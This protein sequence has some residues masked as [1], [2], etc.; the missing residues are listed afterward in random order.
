MKSFDMFVHSVPAS[1]LES[2][3][4]LA[5]GVDIA[6]VE[7]GSRV[8]SGYEVASISLGEVSEASAGTTLEYLLVSRGTET[9][10]EADIFRKP[11]PRSLFIDLDMRGLHF[12][13]WFLIPDCVLF[14]ESHY[15]K[16]KEF[17]FCGRLRTL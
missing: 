10:A 17:L 2:V 12:G 5:L 7:L 13:L 1:L 15:L 16:V 4:F 11:F 8:G 6:F 14:P 9:V 3:A